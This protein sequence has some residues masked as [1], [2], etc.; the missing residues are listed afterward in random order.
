VRRSLG[1]ARSS[2]GCAVRVRLVAQLL[3]DGRDGRLALGRTARG[4]GWR[5]PNAVSW[6]AL[7]TRQEAS[8][9]ARHGR[10]LDGWDECLGSWVSF[11]YEK[12]GNAV[13]LNH[14]VFV[15]SG[16]HVLH[17]DVFVA[18]NEEE[19]RAVAT[20]ALVVAKRQQEPV[21][22]VP[23]CAL[24][25]ELVGSLVTERPC[26]T[27]RSG[28]ADDVLV[29]RP[30]QALVLGET[31]LVGFTHAT[32]ASGKTPG[33][34]E[35]AP[36]VC[37]LPTVGE[38][39]AMGSEAVTVRM[40]NGETVVLSRTQTETTIERL[41]DDDSHIGSVPIAAQL[42]AELDLPWYGRHH[43]IEVTATEESALRRALD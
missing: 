12:T 8:T 1:A 27:D 4:P 42:Q 35:A 37:G 6:R 22:A 14:H 15:T 2:W 21:E 25:H 3:A 16:Y 10:L 23:A 24:T 30:K 39:V 17:L 38:D 32:E 41:T 5:K 33:W 9:P 36:G 20:D 7:A 19:M 31:L 40:R 13:F 18:G 28:D 43:T 11:V 34:I 29:E 26:A